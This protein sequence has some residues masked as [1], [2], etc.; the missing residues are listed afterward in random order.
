M[1][2]SPR[3]DTLG[4]VFTCINPQRASFT[5]I[6]TTGN[7]AETQFSFRNVFYQKWLDETLWYC[8]WFNIEGFIR[9]SDLLLRLFFPNK[10]CERKKAQEK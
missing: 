7:L 4:K 1:I 10:K 6:I 9:K 8:S 2:T 3:N 5:T